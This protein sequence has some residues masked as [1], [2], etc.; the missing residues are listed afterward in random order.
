MI[1]DSYF[2]DG[3]KFSF[4][5][6]DFRCN[7]ISVD[8]SFICLSKDY[9]NNI[10]EVLKNYQ[11]GV[12]HFLDY[13]YIKNYLN[14]NTNLFHIATNIIEGLNQ[15][16]VNIISKKTNIRGFFERFFNFFN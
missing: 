11:I 12:S 15:N 2:I 1:I 7:S 14:K 9:I 8:I 13:N 16:E 5:P 4:F 3:K 6:D 10:E